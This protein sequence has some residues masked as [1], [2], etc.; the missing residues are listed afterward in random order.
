MTYLRCFLSNV[1]GAT[2]VEYALLTGLVVLV[3]IKGVALTG[4][5]VSVG[6]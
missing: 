2:A 6:F 4:A 5:R 1:V 3:I